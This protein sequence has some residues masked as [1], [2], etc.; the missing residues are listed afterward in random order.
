MEF[1]QIFSH[2]LHQESSR[3][4]CTSNGCQTATAAASGWEEA[5]NTS[6]NG[7][8]QSVI[9]SFRLAQGQSV[10]ACTSLGCKKDSVVHPETNTI[11]QTDNWGKMDSDWGIAHAKDPVSLIQM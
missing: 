8:V 1:E 11:P 4:A 5:L 6:N 3:P 10:P 9:D 2:A 7:E